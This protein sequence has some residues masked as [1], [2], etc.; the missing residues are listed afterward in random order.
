MSA[1]GCL[2]M[3]NRSSTMDGNLVPLALRSKAWKK[4][5][6]MLS[7]SPCKMFAMVDKALIF[8][9]EL[10]RDNSLQIVSQHNIIALLRFLNYF[11]D[12]GF[13]YREVTPFGQLLRQAEADTELTLSAS[14]T[15]AVGQKALI[16]PDQKASFH[17]KA[18]PFFELWAINFCT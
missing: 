5:S 9:S 14:R 18:F 6:V 4:F 17:V 13:E 15:T 16:S 11:L 3:S 2:I 7:G 1:N 12:L 8:C 10:P